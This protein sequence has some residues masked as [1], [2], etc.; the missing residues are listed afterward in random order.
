MSDAPRVTG[1]FSAI[2][3]WITPGAIKLHEVD[4]AH[5]WKQARGDM[6]P[7]LKVSWRFWPLV[8][9]VNYTMVRT[10]RMRNLIGGLAGIVW[11]TY[12]SLVAKR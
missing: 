5:V 7:L 1:I 2:D 4:F 10:V 6:W 12:M 3:Y 11:G 8:A 9:G